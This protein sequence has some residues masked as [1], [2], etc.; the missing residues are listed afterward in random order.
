MNAKKFRVV[1]CLSFTLASFLTIPSARIAQAQTAV[2][3]RVTPAA[4]T[5]PTV[6]KFHFSDNGDDRAARMTVDAAGNFY[7]SAALNSAGHPSGLAVLKYNFNGTLQGAFRYKNTPG[8][9]GGS[10]HA[11]K[12]DKQGNIYA[13]GQT[14][15]GGV[16]VSFTPAGVQ[17][18]AA[19]FGTSAGNPVALAIDTSGN[20][21]AAGN[22]GH[23]GSD[24]VGP[25]LEWEI[26]KYSSTGQVLWEQR[27]N[28]DPTLDSRVTDIQLDSQGNA[29]I[30]GTTSNSPVT[31]TN[32]MT[33]VKF[34]P[35]GASL[36]A[37]DFIVTSNS[38]IPGGLVIDAGGNVYATS[39]TNP[40]EGINLASTVKY[41]PNG[42]LKFALQG[43]DAGGTSI[44][45]DPAGDI[46]LTGDT[47][48]FGKPDTIE[49]TKIHPSGVKV[50]VTPIPATGKINSDS[51]GN[52]FVAG[53]GFQITKLN[54]QGTILFSSSLLPGDDV[55][56]AAVDP[57]DN[58]L[59][60][61]FGL[62]A[63][64]NNDIFT[65]RLK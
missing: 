39:V 48:N 47:I 28:G 50:W 45:L 51:A 25:L 49:V 42:V 52:V 37:K 64:F 36:W 41:D 34:D 3:E 27:H 4:T 13:A 38:Q 29:I 46:L 63:Q 31:L 62:N 5:S 20:I 6:T 21:Y 55:S 59:A 35:H 15:V 12:V 24:G 57:F 53:F 60:T 33:L 56:D 1:P 32:K 2:Q 43:K 11:V 58:L 9:F 44:A 30:L 26:V 22:V 19:R 17:R 8:E 54:S 23:G 40:P 61:G 7:V 10:A 65:V 18:W 14:S 16:V